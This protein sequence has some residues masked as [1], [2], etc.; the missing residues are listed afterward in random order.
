V[1]HA[2]FAYEGVGLLGADGRAKSFGV[3]RPGFLLGFAGAAAG[4]GQR[5]DGDDY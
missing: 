4:G 5:G 3:A 2:P 1:R